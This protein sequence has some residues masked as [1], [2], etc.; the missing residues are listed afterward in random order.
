MEV[1]LMSVENDRTLLDLTVQQPVYT[2]GTISLKRD[3][4]LLNNSIEQN[5]WEGAVL[6]SKKLIYGYYFNVLILEQKLSITNLT[7]EHLHATANN[8]KIR[9]D[10]GKASH[11]DS[12]IIAN[13]I[14]TQQENIANLTEMK[15]AT[16]VQL[17]ELLA[18]TVAEDAEFHYPNDVSLS[19]QVISR[20]E[21][22]H[23]S[24]LEEV[25]HKQEKLNN[26]LSLPRINAFAKGSYGNP[27][28][29]LY[30]NEWSE[31]LEA[32][33][34]LNWNFWNWK[35]NKNKNSRIAKQLKINKLNREEFLSGVN[36]ELS[37]IESNLE[38][39][40]NSL[41]T[42]QQQLTIMNEITTIFEESYKL[43]KSDIL[44]YSEKLMENQQLQENIALNQ[45]EKLYQKYIYNLTL[46]EQ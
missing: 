10:S 45:L 30:A 22:I 5:A 42:K 44:T 7:L 27:N 11:L 25:F 24:L 14:L 4:E 39:L 38:Q 19:S 43:G 3:I 12:L 18:T 29:N 34:S 21:L 35:Q 28:Y 6:M 33:V 31:N 17:N 40:D 13:L 46:G 15:Q 26:S 16:I 8:V 9:L 36:S 37:K 41:E 20:Q 2:G 1:G 23:Y 32:G